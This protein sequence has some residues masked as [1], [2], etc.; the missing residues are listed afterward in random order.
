MHSLETVDFDG[1]LVEAKAA[2]LVD[3]EVTDLA[4]LVALELDHLAHAL[5]LGSRDDG[6]IASCEG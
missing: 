1:L 3:E 2:A 5:G 6:T 4:A